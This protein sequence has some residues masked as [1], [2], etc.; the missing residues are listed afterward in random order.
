MK[1]GDKILCIKDHK[2][3]ACGVICKKNHFY[4][5]LKIKISENI[6]D[7]LDNYITTTSENTDK[8]WSI[9]KEVLFINFLI[10]L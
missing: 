5:I 6:S 9:H 10:F 3:N 2:N 8:N 7:E 4:K 1:V